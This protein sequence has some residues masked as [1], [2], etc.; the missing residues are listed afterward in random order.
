MRTAESLIMEYSLFM[1]TEIYM[2]SREWYWW[3]SSQGRNKDMD[4]EN[5]LWTW[6]REG[7]GETA[8]ESSIDTYTRPGVKQTASGKLLYR[9]D[10]S[11]QRSVT[12]WW[13]GVV[14]AAL[15]SPDGWT[16][17]GGGFS[18][19]GQHCLQ[20]GGPEWLPGWCL[21]D[22][23]SLEPELWGSSLYLTCDCK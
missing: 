16:V 2:E 12:S 18:L 20:A 15:R 1:L 17:P 23:V 10:C 21:C 7:E 14:P 8:W 22:H 9:A 11:A 5:T 6:R 13:C 3:T 19:C 4:I